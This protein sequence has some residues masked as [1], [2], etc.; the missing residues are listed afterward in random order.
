[1]HQCGIMK[2]SAI[3]GM[4][5]FGLAACASEPEP[6]LPPLDSTITGA[7]V[8][9]WPF[10]PSSITYH[11][12]DMDGGATA[13]INGVT[14]GLTGREAL[15]Y[16]IRGYGEIESALNQPYKGSLM[17]GLKAHVIGN[18]VYAMLKH[19]EAWLRENG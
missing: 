19:D 13:V 6:P 11:S 15:H 8:K 3:L 9:P 17:D 4:V 18:C 16:H 10:K 14:Y 2:R 1:M 12:T 5:L 7:D